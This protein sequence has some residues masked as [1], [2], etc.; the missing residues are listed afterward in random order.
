MLELVLHPWLEVKIYF[1]TRH[2]DL[3]PRAM[4]GERENEVAALLREEGNRK[5]KPECEEV[6]V[7]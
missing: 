5:V 7:R 6:G 3:K 1:L 4:R 2:G